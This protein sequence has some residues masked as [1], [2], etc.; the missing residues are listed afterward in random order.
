MNVRLPNGQI[1]NNVPEDATKEAIMAKAIQ[2]GLATETDFQDLAQEPTPPEFSLGEKIVGAAEVVGTMAT[3]LPADI[4]GG[5]A[6]VMRGTVGG[7]E[8][9]LQGEDFSTGFG[10]A[11]AEAVQATKD[12]VGYEPQTEAGKE[13]MNILSEFYPI[14]KIGEIAQA[15]EQKMLDMGQAADAGALRTSLAVA[16]P[17]AFLDFVG[18]KIP[19]QAA[20]IP[21]KAAAKADVE[22][23]DL[24]KQL[25]PPAAE[26]T[27]TGI[28]GVAQLAQ[29]GTPE[30]LAL[31][32]N[33]DADFYKAS[34]ELG[35]NT[36]PLASF[37]SQNPQYRAVEQ[38]LAS[39]PAS[40]LD[41]Q[42]RQYISDVSQAADNMIEKYG[43]TLDKAELSTRFQD[44]MIRT[45]DDIYESES[46]VYDSIQAA[47]PGRTRVQPTNIL[48]FI[49]QKVAASGGWEA[50]AKQ[51]P[52]LAKMY[53]QLKPKTKSKKG[54]FDFVTGRE[55]V[56]KTTEQPTYEVLNDIRREI[57]QQ[58]GRKGDTSFKSTETG[59][60]K[61]IYGRLKEDQNAAAMKLDNGQQLIES[62]DGLTIQRKQLED[63]MTTLL[64]KNLQKDLM[65]EVGAAI[66]GLAKGNITKFQET[67]NAIP[68]KYRQ[69][70]MVS[71]LN[72]I[73]RGMGAHNKAFDPTQFTKF[74]NE[75]NRSPATKKLLYSNLPK[76]APQAVESLAKVSKG[77]SV[78]LG[79]RVPTGRV[80]AFFDDN[81]GF[82]RKLMAGGATLAASKAGGPLGGMAVSELLKQ[83]TDAAKSTGDL[84][85]SPGFQ[86]VIRSAVKDGV[87]EGLDIT[88]KTLALEKALEK[89]AKYKRWARTLDESSAAQLASMGFVNYLLTQEDEPSTPLS[90]SQQ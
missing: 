62:A 41:I 58:L 45:I 76:G 73:F 14:K 6:G 12:I 69:E 28:E 81:D 42:S 74:M 19:G 67:V 32:V 13:Y 65:P 56:I 8:S 5:A 10:K 38:G 2:S 85:A 82:L 49:D 64:G 68:K 39:I 37:A 25:E 66:K 15:Y 60:L 50:F 47:L 79:D 61:A 89:S 59:L 27:D 63:N 33:P 77:I 24:Q 3:G 88:R 52:R 75:L 70:V 86:K 9:L 84:L 26:P 20:K 51:N 78:A 71:A 80:A 36:E 83:S 11:G 29:K 23:A 7:V 43:G 17:I 35:I 55:K 44:D 54:A 87:S 1:I 16:G 22:A 90:Q 34:D 18:G 21:A 4:A 31:A 40:Q 72:D 30:E 48:S 46:K 53:R 57:G